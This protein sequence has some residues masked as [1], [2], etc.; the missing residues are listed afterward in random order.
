M[1]LVWAASAVWTFA[2]LLGWG[3]YVPEGNMTACRTDYLST[4]VWSRSYII[5]YSIWVWLLPLVIIVCFY[6]FIVAVVVQHEK[7]MKEQAKKMG[8]QSLRRD[9]FNNKKSTE[10]RLAKVAL[11]TVSLWFIA[12]TPYLIVNIAVLLKRDMVTPLFS[13]WGSVFAKASTVYNPIIYAISHPK[14]RDVLREHLPRIGSRSPDPP[15]ADHRSVNTAFT[16][17]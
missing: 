10:I 15:A 1:A 17:A 6:Y 13:I 3:R 4:D 5:A 14:Y 16:M 8:I 7:Q 2:P 12:W 11:M 9:E